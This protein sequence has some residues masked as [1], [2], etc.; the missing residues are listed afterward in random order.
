MVPS[1]M[2]ASDGTEYVLV[3]V[4]DL[5]AL[6]DAVRAPPINEPLV[7]AILERLRRNL[8]ADAPTLDLDDVLAVTDDTLLD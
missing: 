1:R 3:E 4:G 6:V 2:G 7:R 8:D 5:V